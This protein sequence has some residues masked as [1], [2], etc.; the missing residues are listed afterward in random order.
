MTKLNRDQFKAT[1]IAE[2]KKLKAEEDVIAGTSNFNKDFISID[3]GTNKIR[4]APKFPDEKDFYLM[5]VVH[6]GSIEKEGGDLVRIPI[7]NSKIHGGTKLDIFESYIAFAIEKLTSDPEKAKIITDWQKGIS[8]TISWWAYGWL[9]KKDQ[10]PKFGIYEFKKSVRDQINSLCIIEDEDEAIEVDP[11]TDVDDGIPIILTY[12]PKEKNKKDWHK[13]Q[14]AKNK[15]P[16]TE[17]MFDELLTKEPLTKM[18]RG[19]YTLSNFETACE[20]IR[21]FDVENEFDFF[22]D[23]DFQETLTTIKAQYSSSKDSS[24]KTEKVSDK[25]DKKTEKT[26]KVT[27][28]VE[29]KPEV[30]EEDEEEEVKPKKVAGDKFSKLDREE[31]KEYISEEELEV[32]VKKSDSDEDIRNKIRDFEKS[33]SKKK[34]VLEEDDDEEEDSDDETEAEEKP[35]GS[36]TLE[37]LRAKLKTGKK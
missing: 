26:S 20:A 2:L 1:S 19:V 10:K 34:E 36:L 6:W 18:M 7:L 14:L 25:K 23:A 28:K 22:D 16:L 4:L 30:E 37:Q 24:K 12:N 31:L 35:T 21:N 29:T 27:K 15:F 33:L 3:E 9:L 11:F 8:S 17:E 32:V 5:R 13:I